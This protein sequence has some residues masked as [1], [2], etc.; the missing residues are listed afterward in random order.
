M[1][2]ESTPVANFQLTQ[3]NFD[4]KLYEAKENINFLQG[5]LSS[6]KEALS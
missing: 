6:I 1:F 5:V 2:A 3:L 4:I